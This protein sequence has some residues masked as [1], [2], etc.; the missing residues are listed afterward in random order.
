M[1]RH[2]DMSD[3]EFWPAVY[4]MFRKDRMRKICGSVLLHS[5][6]SSLINGVVHR[7]P[8]KAN[9]GNVNIRV[10]GREMRCNGRF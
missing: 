10:M 4:V 3:A 7:S 1:G 5:S 8:N 2:N 9:Q 6:Q